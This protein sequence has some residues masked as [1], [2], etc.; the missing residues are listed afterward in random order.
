MSFRRLAVICASLLAAFVAIGSQSLAQASCHPASKCPAPAVPSNTSPPTLSG[1]PTQGQTLLTTN[2]SWANSP[3][4]YYYKW[5]DCTTSSCTQVGT[6]QSYTLQAS[7]VGAQVHS[8]VFACNSAGCG[9][10]ASAAET[11][12]GLSS[13]DDPSGV[14]MPVGDT[15][16]WHQVFADNFAGDDVPVGGFSGC[17]QN[18]SVLT[19]HC[20]GLPAAVD[21]N[22]WAY[23]DGWAGTPSTGTYYPSRSLSIQNGVMDMYLHSETI[24]GVDTHIIDAPIPKD[25]TATGSWG[26]RIYGKYVA[27]AKF[28]SLPGYH[29]SF[30]LWP[31]SNTWPRDGEIDWP[32]GEM[33]SSTT[34]AFMHWQNGTSGGDQDQYIAN[35]PPVASGWHTYE[36]D[37]TASAVTFVL[38]GVQIGQ[39]TDPTKIPNTPMHLVLQTGASFSVT[40]ADA[41]AGHAQVDWVTEYSPTP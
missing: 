6:A 4:S 21:S 7:D 13:T 23:P 24:N 8:Q 35:T 11:V 39:S 18:G 22:W 36:I 29:V 32:E 17:T 41:T 14:A 40:P 9:D 3:T 33:D 1:T 26:G 12:S 25:S 34:A 38:D 10:A 30:L 2:G 27:R 20:S 15:T 5:W 37:W 28:D 19:S 31:D 16:G